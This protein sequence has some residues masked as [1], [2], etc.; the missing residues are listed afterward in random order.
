MRAT[1]GT[2]LSLYLTEYLG[3]G[4]SVQGTISSLS[5]PGPNN[6]ALVFQ[7]TY[8][9]LFMSKENKPTCVRPRLK[10]SGLKRLC[11]LLYA[12]SAPRLNISAVQ[13]QQGILQGTP[14]TEGTNKTEPNIYHTRDSR[15]CWGHWDHKPEV[16][17]TGRGS[18]TCHNT[19]CLIR[20]LSRGTRGGRTRKGEQVM[21]INNPFLINQAARFEV[22]E[23][24][25][26]NYIQSLNVL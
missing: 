17:T 13:R 19:W 7:V 11:W 9:G 25:H 6:L 8:L 22:F 16:L 12:T 2:G 5:L 4:L 1:S 14:T 24:P 20:E 10:A 3:R 21:A 15:L 23:I 26:K 18:N